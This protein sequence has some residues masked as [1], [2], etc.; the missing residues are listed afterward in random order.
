MAARL[1]EREDR[2]SR[3]Q[4]RAHYAVGMIF[5]G[6]TPGSPFGEFAIASDLEKL[7]EVMRFSLRPV[8]EPRSSFRE[9]RERPEAQE[10]QDEA[11]RTLVSLMPGAQRGAPRDRGPQPTPND[12]M[13]D[14]DDNPANGG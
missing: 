12:L 1:E 7:A 5:A 9:L 3:S 11:I 13:R 4:V 10:R 2:A 6:D 8:F 14:P